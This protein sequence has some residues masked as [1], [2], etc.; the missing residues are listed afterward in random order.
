MI[1]PIGTLVGLGFVAALLWSLFGTISSAISEPTPKTA[2]QVFHKEAEN[3]AWSFD[4]P[5]GRYDRAQLQR[6]FQVWKEACAA[7]HSMKLVSF[8]NLQEI[9][10]NEAE[11][12]AI[13]KNWAIEQPTIDPNT[14]EAT[15]RKNLPSDRIPSPYPN[16]VAARAANNNALPP[17]H[18]LIAKAREGGADYIHGLLVGYEKQQP[19]A[20][21]K[22]F[23][24]AK[25]GTGLHYNPV[26]HSLNIAMAPPLTTDGQV[27]YAPGQPKP[28]V[29][30]MSRDVTAFL[31]WAAEPKL[32]NR[33]RAGV[34][35][36]LFLLIATTLA[37][38]SYR[39]IWADKKGN[40]YGDG[41][42]QQPVRS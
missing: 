36:M 23:P 39:N 29:D 22:Q 37:Y 14:G 9:G 4:G 19:A 30:Q 3:I 21:L 25:T 31:M 32:E 40:K 12:K 38:L 11:V 26:F 6:G 2:E 34:S 18:S 7:C 1:R 27:T 33:H 28:T 35:V 5:F 13:A 20:L 8:R 42:P 15:T 16:D 24:E 10:F 17:D 41:T